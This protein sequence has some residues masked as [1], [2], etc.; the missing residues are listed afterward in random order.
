MTLKTATLDRRS[1]K[2]LTELIKSV[3]EA[4]SKEQHDLA[5]NAFWGLT[6]SQ[7]FFFCDYM[8]QAHGIDHDVFLEKMTHDVKNA[9]ENSNN[10][11]KISAD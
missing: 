8:R 11:K 5:L 7:L 3:T 4:E 6:V 9:L 10:V 1:Q 2:A